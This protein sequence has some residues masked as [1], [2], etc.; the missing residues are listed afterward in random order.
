MLP[1]K[2]TEAETSAEKKPIDKKKSRRQKSCIFNLYVSA[3]LQPNCVF[4]VVRNTFARAK[5]AP[6][7]G[8]ETQV[9]NI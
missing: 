9:Y 4:P 2:E 8:L 7:K 6:F 5:F 1:S 3:S